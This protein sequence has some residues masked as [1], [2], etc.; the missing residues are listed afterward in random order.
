MVNIALSYDNGFGTQKSA[1]HCEENVYI[2]TGPSPNRVPSIV[3]CE[4]P[5]GIASV[6]EQER[7]LERAAKQQ[8][9]Q[10]Q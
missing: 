10:K 4:G 2:R 9:N 7:K 1:P 5:D 3:P 8:E 6:I